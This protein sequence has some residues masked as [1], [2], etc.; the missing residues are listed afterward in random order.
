M[1]APLLGLLRSLVVGTDDPET[2]VAGEAD[3]GYIISD[4]KSKRVAVLKHRRK[5]KK[6]KEGRKAPEQ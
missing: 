4:E 5:R 6:L 3:L 2:A 1:T